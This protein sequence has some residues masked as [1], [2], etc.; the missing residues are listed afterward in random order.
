MPSKL[1]VL[2]WLQMLTGQISSCFHPLNTSIVVWGYFITSIW[3]IKVTFN[4]SNVLMFIV[5]LVSSNFQSWCCANLYQLTFQYTFRFCS[6]YVKPNAFI[7]CFIKYLFMVNMFKYATNIESNG[8]TKFYL[9]L[10]LMM[11]LV[12][13]CYSLLRNTLIRTHLHIFIELFLFTPKHFYVIC[14]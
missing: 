5:L 10:H 1:L 4:H 8:K 11:N 13:E 3:H 14:V 12:C 6:S 7:N 9:E 2:S